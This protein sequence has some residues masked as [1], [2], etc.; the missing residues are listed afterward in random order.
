MV[1]TET[2]GHE[3]NEHKV[4]DLVKPITGPVSSETLDNGEKIA[5][6]ATHF[7]DIMQVLGLD[8]EDDSLRD[9]PK[10]VAKMYVNEIFGGLDPANEPSITLFENKYNYRRILLEKNIPLFS[11]SEHHFVPIIGKA[12]IAY[13]PGDKVVGLSKLNRVVHYFSKR[14]QVQERLT[15]DIADY[16]KKVLG[17]DD[18][19]VIINAEHL[20][21]ASRGVR[22]VDATTLTSSFGGAFLTEQA[23]KELMTLLGM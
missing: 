22:D 11:Y 18:V 4:I 12:H 16:L 19:A 21:V 1:L 8:M 15:I 3:Y 14:P 10:R 6:I 20:C 23:N 13:V 7:K 5:R 17:T 2:F 9:T